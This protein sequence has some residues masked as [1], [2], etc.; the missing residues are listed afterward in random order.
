MFDGRNYDMKKT[1][2]IASLITRTA[3]K[4]V[5]ETT[6]P[7]HN[8]YLFY[9]YKKYVLDFKAQYLSHLM[10]KLMHVDAFII[11]AFSCLPNAW[12][13]NFFKIGC[14]GVSMLCKIVFHS[15]KHEPK[16]FKPKL[17]PG[18]LCK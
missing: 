18:T 16:L 14:E 4:K 7:V 8:S 9:F 5:L 13:A 12:Q 3:F 2:P 15:I 10:A 17:P 1:K 11:D 6:K